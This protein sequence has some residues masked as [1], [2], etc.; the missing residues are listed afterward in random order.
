MISRRFKVKEGF[1]LI[2]LLG[3]IAIIGILAAIL[4]TS[5]FA[6][7]LTGPRSGAARGLREQSQTDGS[8]LQNVCK[9]IAWAEVAAPHDPQCLREPFR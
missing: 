1:T 5:G 2:E 4:L 6:C 9:R 8:R 3:V 7:A